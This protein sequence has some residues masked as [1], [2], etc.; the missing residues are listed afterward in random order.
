MISGNITFFCILYTKQIF[1]KHDLLFVLVST[2][3][4]DICFFFK[5]FILLLTNNYACYLIHDL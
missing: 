5:L 2:K 3:K 4:L 1:D